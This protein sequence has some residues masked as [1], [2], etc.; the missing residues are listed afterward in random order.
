VSAAPLSNADLGFFFE[1][2]HHVLADRLRAAAGEIAAETDDAASA[3]AMG[4][5][6][7]LY[8]HLL[9]EDG[10]VDV[11]GLCLV[12]ELLG[13]ASPLAD[14]I[15]AVQGLGSYPV[16]L[17]GSEAQKQR[18][19]P[20]YRSGER[21]TGFAL[22]EPEAGSDVASL[23]A[24][25]ER[26]GDG[27]RLS[28]DKTLISNVG[29]A[30]DLVVFANADPAAGRRG[31][32]AFLVACDAPGLVAERIPLG[33]DHPIGSLRFEGTP[34]EL[35]GEVG[36]GFKLAMQTLDTFR[37]TVGAAAVGMARRALEAALEHVR[38]RRQFGA[39]LSDQQIVRSYLA[40]MA[41]ELDAARLLV[42]RAAHAKDAGGG[43][44]TREAAMAKLYAT[45]AAQRIID[46]AVQLFG[47]RGV[48]DGQVVETL[49]RAIRPLRIYEGTSEI[50]RLIIG[51]AL[52]EGGGA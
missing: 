50:Q 20:A 31:I 23:R 3:K 35:L 29:I 44:V 22:T 18:L 34:A 14:A 47:G 2:R 43:R 49:Y 7:G 51:R 28:G 40:E 5:R 33:I 17:A 27:W 39:P 25:A 21:I 6:W 12:R 10:R 52:V 42:M 8:Q 9:P 38:G 16:A 4:A 37:V 11:R 15:F 45:E 32:T 36:G 26:D 19:L 1:H 41:T 46:T 48:M 13:Y 24:V 30:H